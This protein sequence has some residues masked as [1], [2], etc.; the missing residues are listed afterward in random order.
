MTKRFLAIF[1]ISIAFL[2]ISCQEEKTMANFVDCDIE[3]TYE[4]NKVLRD[5]KNYF[6]VSIGKNWKRELFVDANQSRIY[7]ADTTRDYSASFIVDITRFSDR[8]V[9]DSIFKK[10]ITKNINNANKSYVIQEDFITYKGQKGYGIFYFEHKG[11]NPTYFMEFYIAYPEHYYLLKSTIL[12][13]ENF[14]E[15]VCESMTVLN[16]FNTLP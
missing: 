9:L 2:S 7:A 5:A 15:N 16:S 12:G 3:P 8:I 1:Y 14:E 11:F 6:E 13:N 10:S 4:H